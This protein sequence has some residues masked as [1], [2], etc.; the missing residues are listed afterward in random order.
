MVFVRFFG[1]IEDTKKTFRNYLT[2]RILVAR[3]SLLSD[4]L[5]RCKCP[6]SFLYPFSNSTSMY[7]LTKLCTGDFATSSI[8]NSAH[9]RLR[10]R[11]VLYDT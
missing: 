3:S 2:F 4:I 8:Y 10:S 7:F 5:I 6:L 11:S 9:E 1:R